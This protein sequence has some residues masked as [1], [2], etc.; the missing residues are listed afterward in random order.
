MKNLQTEHETLKSELKQTHEISTQ[1]LS[2]EIE[3]LN[4]KLSTNETEIERLTVELEKKTQ[5]LAEIDKQLQDLQTNKS[6]IKA[7]LPY[8]QNTIDEN[9]K[10]HVQ[11]IN[12]V[13]DE[14]GKVLAD[15]KE[16]QTELATQ[17]EEAKVVCDQKIRELQN[18]ELKLA[19]ELLFLKLQ[20][21]LKT[22]QA[23][24]TQKQAIAEANP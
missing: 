20:L 4:G 5:E 10:T 8:L 16:A 24:E 18:R 11:E 9:Q 13:K 21:D 1:T 23:N 2:Q 22:Q 15:T 14:Y 3:G 12:K 19:K 7:E 17:S 6:E